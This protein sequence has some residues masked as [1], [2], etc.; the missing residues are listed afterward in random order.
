[1]T[2]SLREAWVGIM[3]RSGEVSYPD[4][5]SFLKITP[6]ANVPTVRI[7]SFHG[8]W[9][10]RTEAPNG[11][12]FFSYDENRAKSDHNGG[13][14]ISP[15]VPWDGSQAGLA[16]FLNGVGETDAGGTGC[17]VRSN[18]SEVWVEDFGA[19]G[20]GTA[21]DWA[22]INAAVN[23]DFRGEGTI[24]YAGKVKLRDTGYYLSKTLNLKRIVHI[25]GMYGHI[26]NT[27]GCR[28]I[29]APDTRGVIVNRYNTIDDTVEATPSGRADGSKII[30]VSVIS[31]GGSD[32]NAHGIW[33][34][35]RAVVDNMR[36]HG[37][38]GNGIQVVASS[39]GTAEVEGNAN[40][41]S[42]SN[43]RIT[44]NGRHGVY[45]DGA[46]ANSG[47]AIGLDCSGNGRSGIFDSS[48]LGNTYIGCH[49]ATNGVATAG[50][51]AA[52]QSSFVSY[53]GNR[54]AAHWTAT[55]AQLVATVPGTDD[56][57]W[58]LYGSGSTHPTIPLWEAG[59]LEGTYF[60]AFGYR[61][62]NDNARNVF[63]GCYWEGGASGN[64]FDSGPTQVLGGSIGWVMVGDHLRSN[65]SGGTQLDSLITTKG[66]ITTFIGGN[67]SIGQ[68]LGW[69]HSSESNIWR[70]KFVNGDYVLDFAN[71][72]SRRALLIT[73]EN[74]TERY[75]HKLK[76]SDIILGSGNTAKMFGRVNY[77]TAPG[78]VFPTS[79]DYVRGDVYVAP[80]PLAGDK[81]GW[82]CTTS[83][84]AGS[85]A[86]FKAFGAIDA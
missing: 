42:I 69:N 86:V 67:T 78:V 14:I 75:P 26:E 49:V 84:T 59:K 45:V 48:F 73:G 8:G 40:N 15:T 77:S 1:L 54:Y 9:A 83:G 61:A 30:G 46:D 19:V 85:T 29:F 41:F 16:D 55:E 5:A 63:L 6:A 24:I 72:P 50:N 43:M 36:V 34:R 32:I 17:W 62:D 21:D 11:G 66:D 4:I 28:L 37:F 27:S 13:T 10:P 79:G 58:V 57:V 18:D 39:R 52:D 80:N 33:L 35:A 60:Q 20:D 22:A 82:V 31:Q 23:R 12:G 56:T 25:E 68:V 53:G 76:M 81:I 7:T 44:G 47:Y 3:S 65:S 2:A 51:N 70:L 64:A 74:T 38:P 71:S